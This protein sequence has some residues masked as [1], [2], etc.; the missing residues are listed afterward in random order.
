MYGI[1][2]LQEAVSAR[3]STYAVLGGCQQSTHGVGMAMH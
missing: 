2:R 3:G 1:S